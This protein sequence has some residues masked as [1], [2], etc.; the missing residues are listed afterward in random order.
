[1]QTQLME[2][3]PQQ[4]QQHLDNQ[5]CRQRKGKHFAPFTITTCNQALF[6][7]EDPWAQSWSHKKLVE[8]WRQQLL[9]A[10][11]CTSWTWQ[12]G[13]AISTQ[14]KVRKLFKHLYKR[15][16]MLFKKIWIMFVLTIYLYIFVETKLLHMQVQAFNH[17]V[18]KYVSDPCIRKR[19]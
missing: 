17:E 15:S 6:L 8:L 12:W 14:S 19:D 10:T 16:Y 1:V 11:W 5:H 9:K 4:Q 13:R 3:K 18:H 7:C 2:Q